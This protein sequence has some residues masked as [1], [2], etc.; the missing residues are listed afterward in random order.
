MWLRLWQYL[1][2]DWKK[3]IEAIHIEVIRTIKDATKLCSTEKLFIDLG[4]D[5]CTLKTWSN[6]HKLVLRDLLPP[7]VS[8]TT[9]YSYRNANDIQTLP[10][11]TNLFYDAFSPHPQERTIHY[12]KIQSRHPWSHL[13]SVRQTKIP[14]RPPTL[15]IN[16]SSRLGQFHYARLRMGCSSFNS[17]L[18]QKEYCT[19]T[20]LIINEFI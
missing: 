1:N 7:L 13:S 19:N 17:H 4:G 14:K 5:I 9:N 15:N 11:N 2:R 3:R 10:T 20:N 16:I 8:E 18:H 6:K 12:Q